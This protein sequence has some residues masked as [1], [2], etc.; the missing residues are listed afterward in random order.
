M[1]EARLPRSARFCILIQG[2]DNLDQ[3]P[4]I[5]PRY[6]RKEVSRKPKYPSSVSQTTTSRY[7]GLWPDVCCDF[8][9]EEIADD[10]RDQEDAK[11]S[12]PIPDQPG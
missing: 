8:L 3:V 11:G 10:R 6:F 1:P 9:R 12:S 7:T 4:Y 2:V 5:R